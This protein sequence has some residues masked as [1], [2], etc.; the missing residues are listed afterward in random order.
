MARNPTKP[1]RKKRRP[2]HRG[3]AERIAAR[4]EK[5]FELRKAGSHY[6]AI[7][8]ALKI[9]KSTVCRDIAAAM[10]DLQTLTKEAAEDVR[11][12]ELARLDRLLAKLEKGGLK[13]GDH[14]AVAAAV[15]ISERRAKLLG[16]DAPTKL[17]G[18]DGGALVPSPDLSSLSAEELEALAALV[19]KVNPP[20]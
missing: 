6:S 17:A 4:R 15:R 16:L 2:P 8:A 12:L 5:V 20:V 1:Q 19:A 9:N 18:H 13:R 14:R 10:A 7:G 3:E 11:Q